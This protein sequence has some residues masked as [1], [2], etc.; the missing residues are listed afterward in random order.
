M[1]SLLIVHRPKWVME[2]KEDF[3]EKMR[4][5]MSISNNSFIVDRVESQSTGPIF[6]LFPT[7]RK[8]QREDQ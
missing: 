2:L 6:S 3:T 8:K 5:V 1:I 7:E 4:I